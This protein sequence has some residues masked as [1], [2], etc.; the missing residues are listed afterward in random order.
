MGEERWGRFYV[1]IKGMKPQLF[2]NHLSYH[3]HRRQF[4]LQILLPM[5][6]SVLLVLAVAI[7]TGLAAFSESG[8][9]PRW[10]AISTIWLVI[11]VMIFGLIFLA[12]LVG[13]IYLLA[14]ALQALPPYTSKVQYYVNRGASEAKRFSDMATKPVLFLEGINASLKAI[15]G[16]N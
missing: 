15:F 10:A 11:P 3:K 4:W 12:L 5:L 6:V 2:E 8:D 13:L 14:Q 7:L 9:A 1:K 16:R